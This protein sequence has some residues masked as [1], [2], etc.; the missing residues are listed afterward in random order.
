MLELGAVALLVMAVMMGATAYG[1][2]RSM[3]AADALYE[4]ESLPAASAERVE[5]LK[6]VASSYARY[7]AGKKAMMD[8]G[9]YYMSEGKNAEAEEQFLKL[10]DG[11]RNQPMLRIAALHKL[12]E[13]KLANDDPAAAADIYRKAAA[14]PSNL[15]SKASELMAA[16]C[17]EKVGD[18]KAAED[19]YKMIIE[20]A[21]EQDKGVRAVSEERLLWLTA[22]G[23]I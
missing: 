5:K 21:G 16:S 1:R 20:D 13:I 3:S 19:L 4:A 23:H 8:L 12:A 18:Y 15:I 22:N 7:F 2:H 9:L 6:E 10:S 17:L 11:S 14:D